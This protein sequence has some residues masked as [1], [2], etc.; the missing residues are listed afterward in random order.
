MLRE[1]RRKTFEKRQR[2]V[3]KKEE[4]MGEGGHLEACADP[5]LLGAHELGVEVVQDLA[6]VESAR[7][8]EAVSNVEHLHGLGHRNSF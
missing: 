7:R 2:L 3:D 1:R 5:V 6:L 4:G 8:E